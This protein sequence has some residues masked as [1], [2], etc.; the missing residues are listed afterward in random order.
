MTENKAG[1]IEAIIITKDSACTLM[2]PNCGNGGSM[3]IVE[4]LTAEEA[5]NLKHLFEIVYSIGFRNAAL[6]IKERC[7]ELQ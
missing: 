7:M 5:V 1:K 3:L 2:I 4:K 6:A